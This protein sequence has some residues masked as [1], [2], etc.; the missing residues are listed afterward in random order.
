MKFRSVEE[1][2]E[3]R[4]T[5]DE[6]EEELI[7]QHAVSLEQLKWRRFKIAAL[8]DDIDRFYQE[9]PAT[10]DE[11]FIYGGT[12]I[13]DIRVLRR[14]QT[15]PP[16]WIGDIYADKL[17]EDSEGLLDIYEYPQEKA[18]YVIG[19]DVAG[20]EGEDYSCMCIMKKTFPKGLCEQV[21]EWHGKVDPVMLGQL[22]VYV[23]H[24]YNDAMLAIELN[25]HGLTTQVEAQRTYWNFY[26]WQYFDRIGRTY[27]QKVGWVTSL[28]TK[29]ILVDRTRAC[30]RDGLVGISSEGLLQEL[31]AYVRIPDSMSFGAEFGNDDRVMAFMIALTTLY[32]DDPNVVYDDR[33]K[34]IHIDQPQPLTPQST[35]VDKTDPRGMLIRATPNWANL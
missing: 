27:T 8:G 25:N 28:S 31:L 4:D 2:E 16:I 5:L 34:V 10:E 26:R 24:F 19:V 14:T 13:F 11:A 23:A 12:P 3:L 21:A 15:R 9:Y 6:E 18:E 7:A 32:I 22:C 30:L 35:Y 1:E 29:P 20:G 17:I 33:V